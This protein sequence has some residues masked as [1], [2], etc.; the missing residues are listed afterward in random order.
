MY[1]VVRVSL[2]K[3]NE[4]VD[5]FSYDTFVT[6]ITNYTFLFIAFD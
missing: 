4:S 5:I 3:I 2:C 1:A 6:V